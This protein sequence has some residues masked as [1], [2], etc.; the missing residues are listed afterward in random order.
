MSVE[1]ANLLFPHVSETVED[2]VKKYPK[3]P[4]GQHVSR[5]APS[6]TGFMHIGTL[7]SG[8]VAEKFVHQNNKNWVF[9]LRIEDTDKEREVENGKAMI[10]DGLKSFGI[11]IDEGPIGDNFNDVG[12]YGPYIQSARKW[13]YEIFVKHFVAKGWAY[14]CR[15]TPEEL[16]AVRKQQQDNKQIP[17]IYGQYSKRRDASFDEQKKMIESGAPFVVRLRSPWDTTKRIVVKDLIKWDVETQDNFIDIVLLKAKDGLP[18]YHMAH[19]VDDYLMGTTHVI[20]ADE[21]FASVPLHMQLFKT[22]GVEP[23]YYAH[24]SPLLKLDEGKKRKLSKRKDP[25]ADIRRF[26][27]QGY[28]VDAII[29]FLMNIVDPSFE[30]R[31]KNNPDKSH[32]DFVFEISHMN[33]SGALFDNVKLNFVSKE[34]ISKLDKASFVEK[35]LERA[36]QYNPE[37]HA[38]ML[39]H[40]D[41]TFNALNIERCTELDPKRFHKFSDVSEQLPMFYDEE[42]EAHYSEKPAYPENITPEVIKQ[43]VDLYAKEL[44]LDLDKTAR[45]EQL[46]ELGKSIG[47]ATSNAEFKEGGY[48]GKTGDLAMFLRIQLLLSKTTPDLCETMKVMWKERVINRLQKAVS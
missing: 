11:Q 33:E 30:E 37:L 23:P 17:G 29:E 32:K 25:E 10:V 45:F 28:P 4:E 6:P 5:V 24:I 27:A 41:Y 44:N 34:W 35:C 13:L 46:K 20:R 48:I 2:V 9:F 8:M 38:V 22:L 21:W 43:F 47:F 31:Q 39:K 15:M 7:Y 18:T 1:L 36:H 14:P 42:Y 40:P 16:D 12:Q 3:R 19:L 26:F